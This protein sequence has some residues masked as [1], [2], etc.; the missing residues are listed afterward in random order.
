MAHTLLNMSIP[1]V[2]M[3][4]LPIDLPTITIQC[5]LMLGRARV[6]KKT[7]NTLPLSQ[8]LYQIHPTCQLV[9]LQMPVAYE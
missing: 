2:A 5:H 9:I 3:N 1:V 8:K 4:H 7:P 6:L